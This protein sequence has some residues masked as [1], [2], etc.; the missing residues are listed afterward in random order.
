MR[1]LPIL[2]AS[3]LLGGA[4]NAAVLS[5]APIEGYPSGQRLSCNI[6]NLNVMPRMVTIE[7]LNYSGDVLLGD[8]FGL[9]P[10]HGTSLASDDGSA[11]WC[12]YTVDGSERSYRAVAVYD[13]DGKYTTAIPA[14]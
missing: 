7:V 5:S 14:Q 4:A 9:Q 2:V 1:T 10:N 13:D 8:D 3:A 11:A 6:V 12:R